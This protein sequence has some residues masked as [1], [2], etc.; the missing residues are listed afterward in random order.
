M[1]I[2]QMKEIRTLFT[3]RVIQSRRDLNS[4]WMKLVLIYFVPSSIIPD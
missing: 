2:N 1:E 4:F 3:E